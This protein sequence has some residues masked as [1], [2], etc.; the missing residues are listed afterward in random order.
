MNP[1][2]KHITI[3]AT[4]TQWKKIVQEAFNRDGW[5]MQCDSVKREYFVPHHIIPVGRGRLDIVE[6]VL[7]LCSD[8]HAKLHNGEL[9]V[10]VND[11]IEEYVVR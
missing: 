6:N 7:T 10:S 8:C 11:L 9:D 4:K 2:P 5:C 1:Y 3:K